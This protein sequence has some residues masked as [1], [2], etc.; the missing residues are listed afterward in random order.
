MSTIFKGMAGAAVL[1]AASAM[2]VSAQDY[3]WTLQNFKF[4]DYEDAQTQEL[5]GLESDSTASGTL[6][7]S[8]TIGGYALKSFN[9]TT[10]I[11]SLGGT[12]FAA[13][14]NSSINSL[15]GTDLFPA[16]AFDTHI[17]MAGEETGVLGGV[18][19]RFRL[20]WEFGDL[21]SQMEANSGAGN[22]NAL[23]AL[24]GLASY[25]YDLDTNYY[26]YNDDS[27]SFSNLAVGYPGNLRLS[28]VQTV[29]TPEPASLALLGTGLLGI[30]A[31]R[32][33]KAA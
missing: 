9:F 11:D 26:R 21:A 27:R 12:G 10:T 25:E 8:K 29:S 31:A 7:L 16:P 1:L 5:L 4:G 14:Y 2:S 24:D 6:V 19:F 23:V 28:S 17:E 18:E 33:R 30:F 15:I 13:T 20:S 22:L 3:T 32:R